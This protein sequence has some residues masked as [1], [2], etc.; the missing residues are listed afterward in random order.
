MTLIDPEKITPAQASIVAENSK[1]SG[2]CNNDW[3]LNV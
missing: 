1:E 2:R 3:R